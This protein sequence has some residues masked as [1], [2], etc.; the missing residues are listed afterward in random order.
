LVKR[1]EAAVENLGHA[2]WVPK[3]RFASSMEFADLY[4]SIV[5][6]G[7][8]ELKDQKIRRALLDSIVVRPTVA[9][10][11]FDLRRFLDRVVRGGSKS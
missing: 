8:S 2:A 10:V 3:M 11:G 7:L 4:S 9:G 6:R 5:W 1:I